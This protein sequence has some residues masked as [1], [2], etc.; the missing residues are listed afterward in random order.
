MD[1]PITKGLARGLEHLSTIPQ[2]ALE[3]AG[4]LQRGGSYDPEAILEAAGLVMGGT[5]FG[6]PRGAVGAGPGTDLWSTVKTIL[7]EPIPKGQGLKETISKSVAKVDEMM[8]AKYGSPTGPV[9]KAQQP[10]VELSSGG[11]FKPKPLNYDEI[12]PAALHYAKSLKVGDNAAEAWARTKAMSG[13][14]KII[15]MAKKHYG[16]K[17]EQ[18]GKE[19]MEAGRTPDWVMQAYKDDKISAQDYVKYATGKMTVPE[20]ESMKKSAN[21]SAIDL[22][23][24]DKT[25]GEMYEQ[26][27][28]TPKISSSGLPSIDLQTLPR[29]VPFGVPEKAKPL[30]FNVAAVHGTTASPGGNKFGRWDY[31]L[32]EDFGSFRLPG[33]EI[34]IHFGSPRAAGQFAAGTMGHARKF[35]SVLRAENPLEMKDIGS[36]TPGKIHNELTRLGFDNKEIKAARMRPGGKTEI[37]NLRDFIKEKGY[38][39]IKYKN[40]VED[41]GHTSYII[42]DPSQ[43]RVPWA[44]FDPAKKSSADLL[45]GLVGGGVVGG[46][47]LAD[48]PMWMEERRR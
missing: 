14:Q 1:S 43:V 16:Y 40:A 11:S 28:F 29:E 35:P 31:M 19:F 37:E 30:G 36:W 47:T 44:A 38:D 4:S 33:D 26:S 21:K 46:A 20:F 10:A 5:A 32:D 23:F 18:T 45:S 13:D 41:P 3:S 12:Y 34:G 7:S 24:P 39:S 25:V 9:M 8:E 15:E 48:L 22:G 27:P 17:P 42:M 6:A 2:R